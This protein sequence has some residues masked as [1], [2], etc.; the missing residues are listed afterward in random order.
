[1]SQYLEILSYSIS[2]SKPVKLHIVHTL[3]SVAVFLCRFNIRFQYINWRMINSRASASVTVQVAWFT[4]NC[5]VISHFNGM[6]ILDDMLKFESIV[7]TKFSTRV[8]YSF[9]AIFDVIEITFSIGVTIKLILHIN[10]LLNFI[11]V[12]PIKVLNTTITVNN[13]LLLCHWFKFIAT[14]DLSLIIE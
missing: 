5:R 13:Y 12:S 4:L 3:S 10:S 8:I 1:M 9:D 7:C 11:G 6:F 2:F 14:L